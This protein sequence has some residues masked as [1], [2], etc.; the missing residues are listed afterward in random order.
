MAAKLL[1]P[2]YGGQ[3]TSETITGSAA[4]ATGADTLDL[5]LLISFSVEVTAA[6]TVGASTFKVQ[7]TFDGVNWSDLGSAVAI[8]LGAV[9]LFPP[10]AG[11]FGMCRLVVIDAAAAVTAKFIITGWARQ[12]MG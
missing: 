8:A 6:A 11:P 1:L 2:G 9:T 4:G 7:Q 10:T 3:Y 5:S 12:W